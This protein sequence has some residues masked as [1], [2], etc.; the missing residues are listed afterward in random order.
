MSSTIASSSIGFIWSGRRCR[1]FTVTTRRLLLLGDVLA[2][3]RS[4][5]L[6]RKLV[7]EEQI[8]QDVTAYQSG[9]ELDGSFGIIVTLRPSRSIDQARAGRSRTRR[10]VADRR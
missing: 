7:I 6:H 1:I 8:A 5:R 4:S 3:G 2:R 10:A 9:R